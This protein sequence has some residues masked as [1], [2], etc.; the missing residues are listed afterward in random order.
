MTR[1]VYHVVP[2]HEGWRIDQEGVGADPLTHASKDDAIR[3]ARERARLNEPSRV[4]V[5]RQG[6]G[7]ETDANFGE[8]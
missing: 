8:E 2:A 7:V 4:V 1:N 3:I 6:G 5:H